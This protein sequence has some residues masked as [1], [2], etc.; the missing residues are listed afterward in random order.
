MN[1]GENVSIWNTV[2]HAISKFY[3]ANKVSRAILTFNSKLLYDRTVLWYVY[4]IPTAL[5]KHS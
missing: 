2:R 5:Y 4:A 3:T 1:D